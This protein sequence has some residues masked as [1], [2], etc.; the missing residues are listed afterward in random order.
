[1]QMSANEIQDVKY[2]VKEKA[3][4]NEEEVEKEVV[5]QDGGTVYQGENSKEHDEQKMKN[6]KVK[7]T[8]WR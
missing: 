4:N 8:F 7:Y 5:G 3:D 1:M 2:Q 6:M